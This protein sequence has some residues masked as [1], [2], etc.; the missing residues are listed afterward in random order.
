MVGKIYTNIHHKSCVRGI[1]K[2][3]NTFQP[4]IYITLKHFMDIYGLLNLLYDVTN[5]S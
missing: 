5:K 2:Y 3:K 1:L 4:N